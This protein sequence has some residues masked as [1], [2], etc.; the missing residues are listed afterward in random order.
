MLNS[1]SAKH[2]FIYTQLRGESDV[3][4]QAGINQYE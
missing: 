2:E 3:P 1:A 4:A